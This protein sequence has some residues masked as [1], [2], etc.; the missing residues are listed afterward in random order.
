[1]E[2]DDPDEDFM[3]RKPPRSRR[4][5]NGGS[6]GSNAGGSSNMLADLM[7]VAL[8]AGVSQLMEM[9]YS[10]SKAVDALKECSCDVEMAVE[11]LSA[12]CC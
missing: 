5:S 10:R 7:Q 8:E 3:Q 12:T 11:Y 9:G 6:S 1:M 4:G 2:D